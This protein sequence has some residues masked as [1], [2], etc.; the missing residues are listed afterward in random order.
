MFK[1]EQDMSSQGVCPKQG[2]RLVHRF[3]VSFA[4]RHLGRSLPRRATVPDRRI[5]AMAPQR[6]KPR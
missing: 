1:V 6:R 2:A 3:D 4:Q 5:G